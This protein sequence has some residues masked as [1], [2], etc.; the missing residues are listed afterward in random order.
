MYDTWLDAVQQ[1]DLAGVC[2]VDMSAAFDVL[3]TQ[4]LLK[5]LE[6]YEFDKRPIQWCWSYL[7]YRSLGEYIQC[8]ISKLSPLEAGFPQCSILNNFYWWTATGYP[9]GR[10]PVP[11][12]SWCQPVLINVEF[13]TDNKQKVNYQMTH[14][15]VMTTRQKRKH[16]DTSSM[17]ITTQTTITTP[18]SHERLLVVC[19]QQDIRWRELIIDNQDS[20]L[21]SLN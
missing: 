21:K 7:N 5:K 20:L 3:D 15:L 6:L 12:W 10:L 1:G 17:T 8:S 13:H 19:V 9:W 4:L 16:I 11:Q 18:S 14:L 2:M